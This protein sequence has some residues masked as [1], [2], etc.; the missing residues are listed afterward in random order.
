MI[1]LA[2]ALPPLLGI[3]DD[4]YYQWNAGLSREPRIRPALYLMKQYANYCARSS[5]CPNDS[6]KN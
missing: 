1:L 3:L 6:M 2:F 4:A 5:K